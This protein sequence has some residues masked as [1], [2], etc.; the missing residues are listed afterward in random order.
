MIKKGGEGEEKA[1]P[2]VPRVLDGAIETD[3]EEEG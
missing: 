3:S 1:K 2:F